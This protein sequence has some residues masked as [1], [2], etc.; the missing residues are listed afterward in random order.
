M[1]LDKKQ[2]DLIDFNYVSATGLL[3]ANTIIGE[4]FDSF[5]MSIFNTGVPNRLLNIVFIKEGTSK[6]EK[7]LNRGEEFFKARNLPFRVSFRHGLEKG[8]LPLLKDKGYT[9]NK[10]ET[11]IF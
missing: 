9:E 5:K 4:F 7:L 10:P 2:V 6:P 8:F 11:V 1:N 3:T